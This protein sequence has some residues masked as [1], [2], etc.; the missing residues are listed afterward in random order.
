M[1]ISEVRINRVN[2]F[3]FIFNFWISSSAHDSHIYGLMFISE[4]A[5]EPCYNVYSMIMM[6]IEKY[7]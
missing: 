4:A 1:L 5:V 2:L 3:S 6:W 7:V